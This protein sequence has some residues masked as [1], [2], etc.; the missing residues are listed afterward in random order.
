VAA[1]DDQREE[2]AARLRE[3]IRSR[4]YKLKD[5]EAK[6]K[7]GRGYVAEALRGNKR[8]SVELILEVAAVLDAD[9]QQVFS[10]PRRPPGSW[11]EIAEISAG[12]AGEA[13]LPVSMRDASRLLQA[14]LLALADSGVVSLAEVEAR[15]REL[16]ARGSAA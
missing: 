13:E 15:L 6:M 7:R 8:L 12:G 3:L 9:P 16:R 5:L 1:L 14:L 2:I 4:G 11:S 10:P